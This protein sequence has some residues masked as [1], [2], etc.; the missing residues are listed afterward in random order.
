MI[1]LM[2]H[3][4]LLAIWAVP[5]AAAMAAS[6]S[7]APGAD[8]R[9]TSAPTRSRTAPATP[10]TA[11]PSSSSRRSGTRSS[12]PTAICSCSIA[13]TTTASRTAARATDRTASRS[14]SRPRRAAVD[15]VAAGGRTHQSAQIS[16]RAG[17]KH[18][19]HHRPV[20]LQP[21]ERVKRFPGKPGPIRTL[22]PRSRFAGERVA[23]LVEPL[24]R[25]IVGMPTRSL[26]A[27]R[28]YE[29]AHRGSGAARRARPMPAAPLPEE[30]EAG[31]RWSRD[32]GYR[33]YTSYAS[34]DDLPTRDPRFA[35]LVRHLNRHVAAFAA[36]CAFDLGG[37]RLKLDSLW[38]NVLKPGGTHSRAY[39]SRTASSPEPSTSPFRRAP[40]RSSWRTRGC[41]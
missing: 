39:P 35:E 32:H 30:D 33:G 13:S 6:W 38:V 4:A 7:A 36:D 1:P 14:S 24:D 26:F 10:M 25:L 22:A 3:L 28:F 29:G 12:M 41:R 23:R 18:V 40:A 11:P 37:R 31:R 8:A 27:T 21:E 16:V 34:L 2:R 17:R 19:E 5:A 15:D 20:E 9:P